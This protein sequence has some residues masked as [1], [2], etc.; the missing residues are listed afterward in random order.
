MRQPH[1]TK[2]QS[3]EVNFLTKML[4]APLLIDRDIHGTIFLIFL[5]V[6]WVRSQS[7]KHNGKLTFN[8]KV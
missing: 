6:S 7:K 8:V 3:Q 5:P 4:I 1:K 2:V